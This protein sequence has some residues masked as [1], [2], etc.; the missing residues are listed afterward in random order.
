MQ[1]GRI[2]CPAFLV[3]SEALFCAHGEGAG[4]GEANRGRCGV[5]VDGVEGEREGEDEAEQAE[6]EPAGD[7]HCLPMH[8]SSNG[9]SMCAFNPKN[10]NG[11]RASP[12]CSLPHLWQGFCTPS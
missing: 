11:L 3:R 9:D 6:G 8:V 4:G 10:A 2:L 12:G 1:K 7:G 5:A